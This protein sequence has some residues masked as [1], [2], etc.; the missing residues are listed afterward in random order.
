MLGELTA[1][2]ASF[3]ILG[4]VIAAGALGIAQFYVDITLQTI[5]RFTLYE[6]LRCCGGGD[7]TFQSTE[8]GALAIDQ[9]SAVCLGTPWRDRISHRFVVKFLFRPQIRLLCINAGSVH[10]RK[11]DLPFVD[12]VGRLTKPPF[13]AREHPFNMCAPPNFFIWG[14]EAHLFL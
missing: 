9:L 2:W 12:Q 1:F 14:V 11:A 5:W 8:L 7:V 6:M 10:L 3:L 13:G 4:D